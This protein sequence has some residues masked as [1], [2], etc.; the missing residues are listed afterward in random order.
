[1]LVKFQPFRKKSDT[2]GALM[3]I[4]NQHLRGEVT[5]ESGST[6]T[7]TLLLGR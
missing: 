5:E 3:K 2:N 4:D 7:V 1:M 6:T